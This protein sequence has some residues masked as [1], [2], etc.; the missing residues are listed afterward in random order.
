MATLNVFEVYFIDGVLG[1]GGV[2]VS[3][4]LQAEKSSIYMSKVSRR[5]VIIL[6][7]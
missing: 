3:T 1:H 2:V 7:V 4:G 5:R 6:S